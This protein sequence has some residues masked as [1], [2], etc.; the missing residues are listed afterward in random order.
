MAGVAAAVALEGTE[1]LEA[2]YILASPVVSG[3]TWLP[4]LVVAAVG[5]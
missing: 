1:E 4:L 5:L 3:Q 2:I